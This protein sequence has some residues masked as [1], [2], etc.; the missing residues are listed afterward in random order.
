MLLYVNA[1]VLNVNVVFCER[2]A[3]EPR[4][5][6]RPVHLYRDRGCT[7][8]HVTTGVGGLVWR[9]VSVGLGCGG[10]VLGELGDNYLTKHI[11]VHGAHLISK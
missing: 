10:G 2:A 1:V 6:T 7:V 11:H 4:R 3:P 8:P 5:G 9:W